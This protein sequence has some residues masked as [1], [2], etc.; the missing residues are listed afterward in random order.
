VGDNKYHGQGV[1]T[2]KDGSQFVGEFK[3]GEPWQGIDTD[4]DDDGNAFGT[5]F[6]AEGEIVDSESDLVV[7]DN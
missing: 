5:T 7:S 1:L 6:Y 4:Y 2:Y 3:D